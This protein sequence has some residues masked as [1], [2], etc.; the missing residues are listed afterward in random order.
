MVSVGRQRVLAGFESQS[1]LNGLRTGL[2]VQGLGVGS[3]AQRMR[4]QFPVRERA[5]PVPDAL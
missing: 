3:A 1:V 2:V 5:S 4:V